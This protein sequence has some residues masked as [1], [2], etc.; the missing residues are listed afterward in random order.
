MLGVGVDLMTFKESFYILLYS[1]AMVVLIVA[2]VALY[3]HRPLPKE[4]RYE[5][6]VTYWTDKEGHRMMEDRNGNV[7]QLIEEKP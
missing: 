2:M 3:N 5:Y 7:R 1:V 6:G 4:Y